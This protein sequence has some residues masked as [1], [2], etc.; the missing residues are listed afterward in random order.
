MSAMGIKYKGNVC[1]RRTDENPVETDKNAGE[2]ANEKDACKC[3][4]ILTKRMIFVIIV[5][6]MNEGIH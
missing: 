3:E 2:N 4:Q 6:K 5:A 1:D